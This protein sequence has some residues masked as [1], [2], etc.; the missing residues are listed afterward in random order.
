MSVHTVVSAESTRDEMVTALSG[1]GIDV[2]LLNQAQI[3]KLFK[4]HFSSSL[5]KLRKRD[6]HLQNLA[7]EELPHT[8]RQRRQQPSAPNQPQ[9]A[10]NLSI[11]APTIQHTTLTP[12]FFLSESVL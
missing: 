11:Q 6:S 7:E 9:Q 8:N 12:S 4:K 2:S 10:L 5:P 1:I 3:A